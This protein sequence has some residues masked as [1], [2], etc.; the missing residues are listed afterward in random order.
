MVPSSITLSQSNRNERKRV[1][2]C[3]VEGRMSGCKRFWQ[4]RHDRHLHFSN[5]A[6]HLT[7]YS[8]IDQSGYATTCPSHREYQNLKTLYSKFCRQSQYILYK[9]CYK[10][11]RKITQKQSQQDQLWIIYKLIYDENLQILC[12]CRL[13]Q[14]QQIISREHYCAS[15]QALR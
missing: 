6:D 10:H 5:S 2:E 13:Q 4:E 3:V 14:E 7:K 1:V 15:L 12:K 11:L 8:E 9:Q